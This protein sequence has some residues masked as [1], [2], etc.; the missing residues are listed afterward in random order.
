MADSSEH[1]EPIDPWVQRE[2]LKAHELGLHIKECC[3]MAGISERR[4]Y[5][6][7]RQGDSEDGTYESRWLQEFMWKF[8]KAKMTGK[9]GLIRKIM[10]S[11]DWKAAAYLLDR[12]DKIQPEPEDIVTDD[13]FDASNLSDSQLKAVARIMEGIPAERMQELQGVLEEF[14]KSEE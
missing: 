4:F 3:A 2:L 8:H 12:M 7:K 14:I 6:W 5:Q 1:K 9:S 11:T 10:K 13:E